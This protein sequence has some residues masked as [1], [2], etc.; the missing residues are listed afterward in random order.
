MHKELGKFRALGQLCDQ[1][2]RFKNSYQLLNL[3]NLKFSP[4]KYIFQYI[5]QCMDKIFCVEFHT[6]YFTHTLKDMIFIQH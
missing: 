6:K 2:G 5:F 4:V 3:R 1:G